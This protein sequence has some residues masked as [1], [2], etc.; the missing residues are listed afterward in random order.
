MPQGQLL[1]AA[2]YIVL[3]SYV[4]LAGGD[5][6]DAPLLELFDRTPGVRCVVDAN[7]KL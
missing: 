6:V 3:G 5:A 7:L 1:L 4:I 2:S